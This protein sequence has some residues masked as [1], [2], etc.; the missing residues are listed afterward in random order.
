MASVAPQVIPLF[1]LGTVLFPGAPLA[2]HIFEARY[3][4][5]MADL[6]ELPVDERRFGVI[7]IRSG[8]EVGVDG[9]RA[10][11]DVGCMA[12]ITAIE[13]AP[14]TAPTTSSPSGSTRF[15]VLSLDSERPYLRATV[16]WLSE[17]A[18]DIGAL[19]EI[20]TERYPTTATHLAGLRGVNVRDR[21]R[22]R[23]TPGCSPT[24]WPRPSSPRRLTGN[25]SSLSSTPPAGSRPRR[26]GSRVETS[27]LRELS[28]V[29]A[30]RL[31]D[32]PSSIN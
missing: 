32:V 6:L 22:F 2:L 23:P 7:A 27:L 28:A 19:A 11:H 1:P 12:V 8:R 24:S 26:D 15:R 18:G 21:R 29:P 9:A 30:G 3:R 16:E 4:T 5:L 25:A 20:V 10:L 31:I 17:P 13:P 14:T